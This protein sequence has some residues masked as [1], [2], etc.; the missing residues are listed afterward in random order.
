V[1]H[2][3]SDGAGLRVLRGG[4]TGAAAV[5]DS[6]GVPVAPDGPDL[7][8]V[9]LLGGDR[10]ARLG[11]RAMLESSGFVLVV[12]EG[13]VG[14]RAHAAVRAERPDVVV[15][16]GVADEAAAQLL[17]SID[18]PPRLLVFD[19][20]HGPDPEPTPRAAAVVPGTIGAAELAAAVR[21]VGAGFRITAATR[22]APEPVAAEAASV[23]PSPVR[24]ARRATAPDGLTE[25]ERDVLGQVALGR[26][27]AEIAEA[28]IVSEF[29]VKAHVRN[30]LHKLGLPNRVHA[31]IYAY[32]NALR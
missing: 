12:G 4:A 16:H 2:P 19:P 9:Y 24:P 30:L 26:S 20:D 3:A 21:V 13:E 23:G 25:R 27:N 14:P 6:L 1:E 29:T 18:A 31:V 10:L 32:E 11:L 7:I 5:L 15:L 28:L 8:T 22:P 17:T